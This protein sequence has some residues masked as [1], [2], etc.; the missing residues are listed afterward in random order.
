MSA[1]FDAAAFKQRL[2]K[3]VGA[4]AYGQL[5][6]IGVQ[7][8]S[9]PVFLHFWGLNLY[10]EWLILSAIPAYFGLSDIGFATVA[11]NDMAMRVAQDDR[12][13]ALE[14]YQSVWL[15]ISGMSLLVAAIAALLLSTLPLGSMLALPHIPAAQA[16]AT[17]FVLILYVLVGLQGGVLNAGFR[18]SG[19]YAYGTT[20]SNTT[21]LAE[22]LLA[23][24]TL[25]CG[26]GVVQVACALLLG[27]CG[28]T[29]CQWLALRR[30]LPW[31]R[32]GCAAGRRATVRRLFKPALAFMAFPLGQAL[33]IQGMILVLG[34]TLAPSAVVVFSTYRT[35]TRLL[36]QAVSLLNH[37]VWPEISAAYGAGSMTLVRSLHRKGSMAAFWI[38]LAGAVCL[39]IGGIWVIGAW[40]RHAF[41]PDPLL[42]ALLLLAAFLN[43]LWQ[44][45]SMV[46]MATNRH[47]LISLF[48]LASTAG[49]LLLSAL[50][51]RLLGIDG[52]AMAMILAE[53]PMLFYAI[54]AALSVAGDKF[55]GYARAIVGAPFKRFTH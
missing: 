52:A 18:S 3:G 32:L 53:V 49:G 10:G 5:V 7:L 6:S 21:R 1:A 55:P 11:G 25:A 50:L 40:V 27:R 23:V 8:L 39:G 17:M 9:V 19:R 26:G 38:G 24:A 43:I 14:V 47:Q 44:T 4:N 2:L 45:S 15:L 12:S 13:G 46:L 36:I 22:W 28:G 30:E 31:L 20:L 35:L 51:I 16:A 41:A 42:L 54:G 48:F 37:A 34:L 33:N 29:A